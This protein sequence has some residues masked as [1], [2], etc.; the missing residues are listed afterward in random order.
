MTPF[1]VDWT[2]M[3]WALTVVAAITSAAARVVPATKNL[4]RLECIEALAKN[5][6]IINPAPRI[7]LND[8]IT[9]MPS[10]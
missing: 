8:Q 1:A 2:T 3:T 6:P 10:G 7:S 4:L 9:I 5:F